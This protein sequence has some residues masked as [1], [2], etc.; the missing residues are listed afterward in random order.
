MS[1]RPR[2]KAST[3]MKQIDLL[4]TFTEHNLTITGEEHDLRYFVEL[5]KDAEGKL[6]DLRHQIEYHFDIDGF[7]AKEFQSFKA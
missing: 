1:V 2:I 7:R 3:T 4:H 5:T 6:G